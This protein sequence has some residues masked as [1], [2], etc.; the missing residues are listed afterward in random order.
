[1]YKYL[2]TLLLAITSFTGSFAQ[3]AK[4]WYDKGISL[5]V[6]EN[7]KDAITAFK[8]AAALKS[9]YA[10]ALH[11]LGF[12]YNELDSF[13]D[14]IDVLVKESNVG[15]TDMAANSFELGY[16]Y[17]GSGN[18][19]LALTNLNKAI[20][21]DANY[22]HAYKERG[23]VNFKLNRYD[24]ALDDFNKYEVLTKDDNDDA[25]YYYEKGWTED[26]QK[27]YA[28][29]VKSLKSAVAL[30]DKFTNAFTELGYAEYKLNLNDDAIQHYRAASLL[31][32]NDFHP[33]LGIADTYFENVKNFDSAIVYYEKGT[34]L[35]KQNKIAYYRLGWCYDD[36]DRFADAI[37]PLQSSL[38][39]D[40][41]YPEA[42]KELGYVYYKLKRYDDALAKFEPIMTQNSS[43]ELS[44]YYA[45]F[46]YYLKGE[47]DK[48]K[49]MI[50]E[51]TALNSTRYVQTL[52]KY[53]K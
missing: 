7:F 27:K 28:D 21:I 47:Q 32:K 8:N 43:D 41:N 46:C 6:D 11:Q 13:S 25:D 48:L 20:E 9:D 37:A 14:A 5:K 10:D 44:R 2:V 3:T 53:I 19:A 35:Q 12:C 22:D 51:L 18:Y 36:K 39:I 1:M 40:P 38:S 29:A 4:E 26:A 30:D 42:I 45:G 50:T 16:A 34:Q 33:L 31:D 24:K 23:H 49:Q 15:P 17:S 52:T